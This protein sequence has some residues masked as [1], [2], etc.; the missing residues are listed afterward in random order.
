MAR[1]RH[2]LAFFLLGAF[3]AGGIV[4]P[5]AH[6]VQHAAEQAAAAKR[7]C[8]PSAAHDAEGALWTEKGGDLSALQC[9]LC[10]RRLLVVLP[11][12]TPA[13]ALRVAGTPG[14]ERRGHVASSVVFADWFI[15]GPPSLSEVRPATG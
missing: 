1:L 8:H 14:I 3:V 11:A 6:R 4:G 2:I 7:S 12:P 13:T 15:R 5:V 10:A 9:D